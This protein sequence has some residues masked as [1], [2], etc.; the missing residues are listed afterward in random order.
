MWCIFTLIM[1]SYTAN[2][3]ANLTNEKMDKSIKSVE[4]LI[5]SNKI[6]YGAVADGTTA[7]FFEVSGKPS[8]STLIFAVVWT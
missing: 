1:K 7:K 4:E 6:K 3:T 2:L 5:K 8:K